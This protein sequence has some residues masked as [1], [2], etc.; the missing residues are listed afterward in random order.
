MLDNDKA[1]ERRA[2]WTTSP[3]PALSDLAKLP[4]LIFDRLLVG[5][6]ADVVLEHR[7]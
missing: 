1:L 6:Y 5:R 2:C 3:A 4:D 7:R